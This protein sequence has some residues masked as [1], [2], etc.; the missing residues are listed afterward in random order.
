MLIK[1]TSR[2][3]CVIESSGETDAIEEI[4]FKRNE[5]KLD[6]LLFWIIREVLGLK[7]ICRMDN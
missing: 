4:I 1:F 5:N 2:S 6:I 7:F 3:F